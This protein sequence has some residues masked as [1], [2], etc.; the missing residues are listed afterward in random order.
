M[1]LNLACVEN[2]IGGSERFVMIYSSDDDQLGWT[3]FD[4]PLPPVRR[5][6]IPV[7][8]AAQV[9]V[10]STPT[11]GRRFPTERR[12]GITKQNKG[13]FDCRKPYPSAAPRQRLLIACKI[14][15]RVLGMQAVV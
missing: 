1:L 8:L 6:F 12:L 5:I 13:D 11:P 15:H 14:G 2:I 7:L 10:G 3:V 9:L 4:V